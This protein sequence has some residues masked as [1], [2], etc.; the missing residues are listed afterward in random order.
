MG[1]EVP[2]RGGVRGPGVQRLRRLWGPRVEGGSEIYCPL[3]INIPCSMCGPVVH[4]ICGR[5]PEIW[6]R[7]RLLL[8]HE[9]HVLE[10]GWMLGTEIMQHHKLDHCIDRCCK[11]TRA[12]GFAAR[13]VRRSS[14]LVGVGSE[15][16]KSHLK[17]KPQEKRLRWLSIIQQF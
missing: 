1:P 6:R 7:V 17:H 4:S 5:M 10:A 15:G 9:C 14:K 8:G 12:Q 2:A 16:L 11:G 13:G 3:L